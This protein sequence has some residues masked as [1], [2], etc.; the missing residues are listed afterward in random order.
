MLLRRPVVAMQPTQATAKRCYD[1]H[2]VFPK[3]SCTTAEITLR[4]KRALMN[5]GAGKEVL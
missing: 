4:L 1:H 5:N 3:L 2:K